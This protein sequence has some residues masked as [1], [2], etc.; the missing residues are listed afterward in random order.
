MHDPIP[1]PL[2]VEKSEKL[3]P[4]G[5][6]HRTELK[7]ALI[8][9]LFFGAASGI[10]MATLNNYLADVHNLGAEARGW[11]EFPREL[12]GFLMMFVA[13]A[14]L[15][16]MRETQMGAA[17]ML[18]TALGALGLA[19]FSPGITLL[20]VWIIVWS[21]GDHIIFAVE[22]PI[23]LKLA[24]TG[25]E[26]KR[27]GQ[28]GG[29]RNLGTI[30]GVGLIF[31]LAKVFGDRYDI[32]YSIAAGC[33]F[34]AG[35]FYLK[36]SIGKSDPPSR[37]IVLKKKYG[38]FYAISA[39]FGI[40]KQIFLA[41]GAWVLVSIYSVP[42]STIALLFFISAT[43]GVILRPL[44]GEVID[45]LGE[46]TVLAADEIILILV[47]LTYAFASDFLA[48]PWALYALYAAYIIDNILFALRIARTTY[49]QKIADDPSDITP[50]ISM[51]ITIDHVVAMSLP[52]LSGYIWEAYGYR[53]VFILAGVIAF[54]GFF[55]CLKIRIPATS[56]AV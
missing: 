18:A 9:T 16:V 3:P 28:F 54:A 12:P 55:I 40:R 26:G 4:A 34:I 5:W 24:K 47:C 29:A 23:G 1:S 27:L 36:L 35:I 21:L 53:W 8:A 31:L 38:I 13:G 44:L 50:T 17:A 7:K 51:G 32:F 48:L 14:L 41:F 52:V 11:V 45:I 2:P 19:Y 22:G 25:N 39:L 42:V 56:K 37:K 49:L 15:V 6:S 20:V 33:A 10:F 30:I 46:R 43:L